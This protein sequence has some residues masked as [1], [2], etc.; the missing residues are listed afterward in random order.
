MQ[1]VW[2]PGDNDIGG[3][4]EPI[5]KARID[6]FERS[7]QNS[8]VV[9]SKN[10]L[11]Y[12]VNAITNSFLKLENNTTDSYKIVVSHYPVTLKYNLRTQ[13]WQNLLTKYL[14]RSQN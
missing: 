6:A 1:E 8:S 13:V 4:M 10:I 2:V 14:I 7:Y 5:S 3:E 11:F 9:A 12:K